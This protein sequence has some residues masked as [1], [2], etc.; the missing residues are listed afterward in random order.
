MLQLLFALL[1]S[2]TQVWRNE[3]D[4]FPK[5]GWLAL[6]DTAL[7]PVAR[8]RFVP[9]SRDPNFITV[10]A[11]VIDPILLLRDLPGIEAGPVTSADIEGPDLPKAGDRLT[12]DFKG[13]QYR[14]TFDAEDKCG[15][16]MRIHL[17][18]GNRSQLLWSHRGE[19]SD[20]HWDVLWAGDLDRDGELD[21]LVD[22]SAA[23][24]GYPD[25][26]LLSSRA[27][28]GQMVGEAARF[29]HAAC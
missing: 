27:K 12:I 9:D 7:V 16:N 15:A 14:V 20:A 1:L 6:T 4:A 8:V 22:F 24:A 13:R 17:S 10:D 11:G 23:Y 28:P 19:C 2:R 26:L 25:V 29:N 5:S 21:L 3:V 18:E